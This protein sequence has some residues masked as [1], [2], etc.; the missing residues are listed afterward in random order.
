[1]KNHERIL[2]LLKIGSPIFSMLKDENRQKILLMLC[3]N[4]KLSVNEI[5]SQ[6]GIS[7]PATSHH[8]KLLFDANLVT[9]QKVGNERYYSI[10][11]TDALAS[12]KELTNLLE[13]NINGRND[14]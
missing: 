7:R 3:D 2:E 4:Q 12:L 13:K 14:L 6:L 1:M 5:T 11:L 8:L 10:H 9:V